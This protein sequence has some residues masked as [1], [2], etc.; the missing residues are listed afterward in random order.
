MKKNLLLISL[1]CLTIW[2]ANAQTASLSKTTIANTQDRVQDDVKSYY[3]CL[4]NLAGPDLS[5]QDK[6][7]IVN[8]TED[9]YFLNNNVTIEN[10]MQRFSQDHYKVG[11]YLNNIILIYSK[12]GV[13]IKASE[14][15]KISDL[16]YDDSKHFYFL[17]VTVQRE[18]LPRTKDSGTPDSKQ[19]DIL[20]QFNEKV[21]SPKIYSIQNHK[22]GDMF[23][24]LKPVA[25]KSDNDENLVKKSGSFFFD[26]TPATAKIYIDNKQIQWLKNQKVASEY[27]THHIEIKAPGY[28]VS[29]EDYTLSDSVPSIPIRFPLAADNQSKTFQNYSATNYPNGYGVLNQPAYYSYGSHYSTSPSN[30]GQNNFGGGSSTGAPYNSSP[31]PAAMQQSNQNSGGSNQSNRNAAPA[32]PTYNAAP[33]HATTPTPPTYNTLPQHTTAPTPP[34]FN[35]TP[36]RTTSPA[37]PTYNATPQQRTTPS[38]PTY[39]STP[40]QTPAPAR[41]YSTPP[42]Q[43]VAPAK[44]PTPKQNTTVAPKPSKPVNQSQSTTKQNKK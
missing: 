19:V 41:T 43:S 27:G 7:Q 6:N 18:V 16:Y 4:S 36:Q 38:T 24:G 13:E 2:I 30:S 32:S 35:S 14:D 37:P 3:S 44:S 20:F 9:D 8:A 11:D 23:A 25:V 29:D 39:N 40:Q 26:I 10:D 28:I 21:A 17:A 42:K 5:E 34:T 31:A 15:I 1:F 22:A 12:D 33:Q